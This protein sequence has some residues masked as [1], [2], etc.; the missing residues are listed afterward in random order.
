MAVKENNMT[1]EI[2]S[3]IEEANYYRDLY[4]TMARMNDLQFD[5]IQKQH[6]VIMLQDAEIRKM[7]G[8]T[9]D[10]SK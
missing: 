10:T 9:D 2:R 7:R 4:E 3:L 8:E 6:K 5:T 1:D